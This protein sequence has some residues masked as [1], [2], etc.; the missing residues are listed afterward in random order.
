M[1]CKNCGKELPDESNFC[2]YCMTKFVEENK[3]EPIEVNK[4]KSKALPVAIVALVCVVA[5][6]VGVVVVPKMKNSNEDGGSLNNNGVNVN[7][8]VNT[9]KTPDNDT[10]LGLMNIKINNNG[11]SL[12]ETQKLLVQYFDTDYFRA[13]YNALQRYPQ[14][15]KG[16]QINFLGYVTK[17]IESTDTEYTA[18]VE[19]EAY[20]TYDGFYMPTEQYAV[21]K[22]TH[23]EAR[24]M[25]GDTLYIYGKYSD[26]NTYT[27]DGKSYTVSTVLVNRFT[28][29]YYMD[30]VEP[31]YSMEEIRSVAKHIFGDDIKI[32]YTKDS[33]FE[34][35]SGYGY[36]EYQGMYYTVELDNQSNA[37]FTKYCF[38]AGWGGDITDCKS[39]SYI[40]RNITFSADFEHFYLQVFDENL[41]TYILECYDRSLNKIWSREFNETTSAV[42]DYTAS[43]IYLVANGSMYIIDA[44][45]GEDSVEP[46]YVGAKTAIRKLEDGIILVSQKASDAI[47]KTDLSGNVLWTGNF[48]YDMA[49]P[50]LNN[51][52]PVVQIVNGNYVVQYGA[53]ENNE[54]TGYTYTA[55]ITPDGNVTFDGK[56]F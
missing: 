1:F 41:K 50:D 16:A 14:V 52:K 51:Q 32:R 37:N 20:K 26:V 23:G 45:T 29:F 43:H 11:V 30:I 34:E 35:N 7:N 4:K 5:I 9:T 48:S 38:F 13:P 49:D 46:K 28:Y 12:N 54:Y 47:M 15:Y 39:E 6:I 10:D 33:D 17:I 36:E 24:I 31:M 55:V 25:E 21:I 18:L 42:I 27:V 22:G 53:Y 8:T 44:Q 3:T 56:A 19:Y 2:P 40:N